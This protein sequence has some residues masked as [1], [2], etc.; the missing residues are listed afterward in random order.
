MAEPIFRTRYDNAAEKA[1]REGRG[2]A[3]FNQLGPNPEGP[4]DPRS[5]K[6]KFVSQRDN[7]DPRAFASFRFDDETADR[8][9]EKYATMRM[10]DYPFFTR[11]DGSSDDIANNTAISFLEKY[12]RSPFVED[13]ISSQS[14]I[15]SEEA[16]AG[17][18]ERSPNTAGKFPSQG[19]GV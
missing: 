16:T 17:S 13:K 1:W 8:S 7:P 6:S 19:V 4:F 18:N 10:T 9:S 11:K 15:A 3:E 12:S 14:I 2:P 5:L